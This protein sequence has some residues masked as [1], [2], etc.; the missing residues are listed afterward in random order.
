VPTPTRHI[1][2]IPPITAPAMAPPLAFGLELDELDDEEAV[3][4]TAQ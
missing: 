1:R 3:E 2:A 4:E